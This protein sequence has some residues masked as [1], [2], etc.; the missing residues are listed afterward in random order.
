MQGRQIVHFSF[1]F[2]WVGGG[3]GWGAK[4]DRL[5]IEV[6]QKSLSLSGNE[7]VIRQR[8]YPVKVGNLPYSFVK[9]SSAS[10]YFNE[11]EWTYIHIA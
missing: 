4:L 8:R 2:F 10:K 9:N 7:H 5:L 6:P 1:F 11:Y 3:G